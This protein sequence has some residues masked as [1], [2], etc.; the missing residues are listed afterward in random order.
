MKKLFK[1]KYLFIAI[2]VWTFFNSC[3][4]N[5][6]LSD[7]EKVNLIQSLQANKVTLPNGW[8]ITPHGKQI[9]LHDLPLNMVISP[10][11]KWMAITNN[12]QS[13][14]SIQ[15]VDLMKDSLVSEYIMDKAWLGLAFSNDEKYIY[16]SGGNDNKIVVLQHVNGSLT[17]SKDIVLDSI[18]PVK[19]SPAGLCVSATSL[20]VVSK[21]NNQLYTID[22]NTNSIQNK[23]ALAAEPYTC[24]LSKDQKIL[25]ISLWGGSQILAYNT[26]NQTLA[27]SISVDKNP[28]EMTITEDGKYLYVAHGNDNTVTVINTATQK[29][30]EVLTCSLYPDAPVGTT[31][32]SVTLDQKDSRLYVAN[33]DNNCIAVFDVSKK[34]FSKSLGFIPVGWYPTVVRV[35]HNKVYVANGKGLTSYPNPKGP[36]PVASTSPQYKGANPAANRGTQYIGGLFKGSLSVFSVPDNERLSLF[37]EMVYKNTPYTKSKETNAEGEKNNPIPMKVGD[38]SPI[39]YVFYVIKENR[40]YDQVMG[41]VKEGNGDESLCLFPEKVTPNQHAIAK[42]FVLL[43]NFYVDAEV[44]A[45]GHNW[46]MGAYAND[47]VEKTWVTSYGG[48]GGTYDYE[49]SRKIA[50]PRDGFIWDFAAKAGISYR[51][52]GEFVEQRKNFPNLQHNF[53]PTFPSYDLNIKDTT[54]Y[55]HWKQDFDSLL[56]MNKVPNLNI[57]RFGNDHTAGARIGMPTT[58]AMVADNDLAV[59]MFI[60]HLSKSG[61][62]E[63]TAIF[64]LEDDAQNGSD[65]IDAHRSIA[66]V[67]GGFVKRGYTDHTMYSTTSMLRTM[68]LILGLPPMSQYDAAAVPMWRC[69]QNKADN[70]PFYSIRNNIDLN[71]MNVAVSMNSKKSQ[72]FD[73]SK[74]DL[75]ND[76]EFSRIVWQSV[77]GLNSEMPAPRRAAFLKYEEKEDGDDD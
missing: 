13:T 60:E 46:S 40:T 26:E 22:L 71:E 55:R 76:L 33:A 48:R 73:L 39:K 43:D 62:W 67:A 18:W 6:L 72:E 65:H 20:Y 52:Y 38:K 47:Y 41:D 23:F 7:Q 35:H 28:N 15:I 2:S 36:N 50:F 21:E 69:F 77:K 27:N 17:K 4:T 3:T 75:I 64:I 51:S 44:S 56:A 5:K 49:G 30:I 31:P 34:G 59:G 11:K 8:T 63:Q 16:A 54:R 12:G 25:Y 57:I 70:T 58:Q 42:Q 14:Q 24:L 32:N 45:D 37:T 66:Y 68:E 74:P 29:V 53:S 1:V 9:P 19:V 61:I 10:S